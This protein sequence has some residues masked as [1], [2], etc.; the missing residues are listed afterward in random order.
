[1]LNK[2]EMTIR[3][4]CDS[5]RHKVDL[6]REIA[7]ESIQKA[8][9]TLMKEIDEYER[10]CLSSWSA[11][12]ESTEVTMEDVSKRMRAFLDEQ[13]EH[14]QSV[15]TSDDELTLRLDEARKLSKELSDRKKELKA[16][17]F[18]NK[19]ASFNALF[20]D[21]D[22]DAS[23]LG[24]LTFPHIQLPL[25]HLDM[26]STEFKHFDIRVDDYAFLLPLSHGQRIVTFERFIRDNGLSFTQMRCFDQH[27]RLIGAETVECYVQQANVAQSGPDKFFI[28]DGSHDPELILY[29][30]CLN[31][32]STIECNN[33]S[34]ICCNSQ[35]LFGLWDRNDENGRNC[36]SDS[37]DDDDNDDDDDGDDDGDEQDEQYASRRINVHYLDTMKKAFCLLVPEKYTISR[38]LADKHHVVALS[39]LSDEA[40]SRQLYM[41]IF[42]LQQETSNKKKGNK[43]ARNFFLLYTWVDLDLTFDHWTLSG[44][45]LFGGWLVV[46]LMN[47]KE[48]VW[49]DKSGTRSETSTKLHKYSIW[50]PIY[51]S[52]SSILIPQHKY[53][54]LVKR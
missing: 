34:Q 26:A 14:L 21:F 9:N 7:L 53:K 43:P 54:Y 49:F 19:L 23:L 29:D 25:K 20:D 51:S 48:L 52:G 40:E 15:Q 42:A 30:S 17:M 5:I 27:G 31:C 32:L 37:D 24:E 47:A 50:R 38:I 46:G 16:A 41:S 28:C 13:Q 2:S 45:F 8:S 35:F 10:E 44:L 12:K 11:V 36:E 4:H 6:A 18:N 39:L 33:F 3:E 1:M 22:G